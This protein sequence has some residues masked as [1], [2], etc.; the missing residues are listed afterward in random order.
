MDGLKDRRANQ[1]MNWIP[2]EKGKGKPRKNWLDEVRDGLRR[3][4]E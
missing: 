2:D 4:V 1:V 3:N